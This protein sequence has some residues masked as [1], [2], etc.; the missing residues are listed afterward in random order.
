MLMDQTLAEL[1]RQANN[2]A[3]IGAKDKVGAPVDRVGRYLTEQGYRLLPIHPVRKSAW[4]IA[5]AKSLEYLSISPDIVCVFRAA[6][7]CPE[8]A[9]ETLRLEKQPLLFWMQEGIHSPEA[10]KILFGSKIRV[11]ENMCLMTEHKRLLGGKT[12]QATTVASP[13]DPASQADLPDP[14][15]AVFTCK[16]CG[17][18]CC[19]QGGIVISPKDAMRLADHLGLSVDEMLCAHAYRQ[20]EKY[21]LRSGEDGNCTFFK[22]ATGCEI[23]QARP[24]ICRA[25]PFFRG[26][27]MDKTSYEMAGQDCLGITPD[28]N[29]AEFARLG[30]SYLQRHQLL[31]TDPVREARALRL[32]LDELQPKYEPE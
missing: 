10:G 5:C 19:G 6:E 24:D 17:K 21:F 25:W 27:L 18:C 7:H 1:L 22:Q 8:H 23:H 29:H 26:N 31:A 32:T 15:D 4:G 14:A 20:Q 3:I 12:T 16:R 30:F 9:R 28:T 13:P 11:I 2:I